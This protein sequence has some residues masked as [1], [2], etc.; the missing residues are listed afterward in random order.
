MKRYKKKPKFKVINIPNPGSTNL[1]FLNKIIGSV[2]LPGNSIWDIYTSRLDPKNLYGVNRYGSVG[3][4]GRHSEV[5]RAINKQ[6]GKHYWPVDEE[7]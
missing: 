5:A 7:I 1:K 6:L 3:P 2:R 4:I